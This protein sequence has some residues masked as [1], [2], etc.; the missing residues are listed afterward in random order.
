MAALF[1]NSLALQPSAN[2]TGL[3]SSLFLY[4]PAMYALS[5][6]LLVGACAVQAVL[7]RHDAVRARREAEIVKRSVDSF[8]QTETPI[9]WNALLCN[10]G[11]SGCAASGAASGAV[12]ASPSKSNPDYW[13]TWS[14]DSALVFRG[15]VDAFTESYDPKLQT[16]IQNYIAS[17][18]KLQGVSNPSGSFSNGAGLG[19]PKFNVDLTQFTGAWGRPQRDGPPLRAIALIGY[20]RWLINNGYS[21]TASSVVWPVIK[22]DLA[23]TAQYWNQTGFDLWE[24]VQGSSFFTIASSHRALV[25]GA[26]LASQLGT[27]CAACTTVAP[28][29]LCFLQR[30]WSSSG[31]VVS[32]INGGGGRSGKDVNSIITSIHNFDTTVG[33]DVNTFQ[34]CSDKALANHK[35]VTDSFRS[36]YGVN[37]GLAQ[38]VAVAVGRYSE[39][40]YYNGNPWYLATLAAAEQLYDALIVWKQQGSVTITST[41]LAFFK[42]LV[43]SAAVGTYSS[44]TSTYTSVINAVQT[45]ADGYMNVVANRAQSN[46]SMAEQFD[47]SNGQPVSARDLTWSYSAFLTAAARRAGVVPPSWSASSGNTVP[48]SCSGLSV[49]GSYTSATLTSFPAS[50]TPIS[51]TPTQTGTTPTPTVCASEVIVTFNELATTTWGQNIKLVGNIAALGNWNTASAIELSAS[52]YTSSNPLWTASVVLPAG[53]TIQYKFIKVQP[54]GSVVWESDPNRSYTVPSNCQTTASTSSSWK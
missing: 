3:S 15:I 53:Q 16:Q 30:F 43:P 35:A 47:R 27:T 22:N 48:G 8:I 34:P 39:D 29:V 51:G 40:V 42:D 46:G 50:Q 18:A 54:D 52:G 7:G 38:G 9:A 23:Y 2:E 1:A 36:V 13:F 28:Q 32:N 44:T 49:A 20:A 5:S 24:E 11:T 45:Y 41:S 19:E 17:Q 25:E 14:R 31:Y 12:V 37:S 33:C 10:I 26:A 21:S 6:L 4:Q